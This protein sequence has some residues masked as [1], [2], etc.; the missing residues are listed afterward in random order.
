MA[1]SN[2]AP[3]S[4][5]VPDSGKVT[6]CPREAGETLAQLCLALDFALA[7]Q[8]MTQRHLNALQRQG[9][10]A[11]H[12]GQLARRAECHRLAQR[13]QRQDWDC[14]QRQT[15][16]Q[17]TCDEQARQVDSLGQRIQALREAMA[18][19]QWGQALGQAA[20]AKAPCSAFMPPA[21][22]ERCSGQIEL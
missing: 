18:Q 5:T 4:P 2:M 10:R 22:V 13:S 3:S 11:Y 16:L 19:A 1:P 6:F 14:A 12:Q 20:E 7:R 17:A 21:I 8:A 9:D 15:L